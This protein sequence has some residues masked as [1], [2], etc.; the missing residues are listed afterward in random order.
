[1]DD[2]V[3][4]LLIALM[5]SPETFSAN[6]GDASGT[7]TDMANAQK[8]SVTGYSPAMLANLGLDQPAYGYSDSAPLPTSDMTQAMFD[9]TRPP[10]IP[11]GYQPGEQSFNNMPL[12]IPP[13]TPKPTTAPTPTPAPTSAIDDLK[14][15]FPA[16]EPTPAPAAPA[17]TPTPAPETVVPWGLFENVA[18]NAGPGGTTE[19]QMQRRIGEGGR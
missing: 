14:K 4:K 1:M 9:S 3:K 5:L 2:A 19:Y 8:K 16:T 12:P 10:E 6:G 7:F 13:Q 11:T 18:T 17:A 15:L